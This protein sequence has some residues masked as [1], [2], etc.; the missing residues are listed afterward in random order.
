MNKGSLIPK[1]TLVEQGLWTDFQKGDDDS[2]GNIYTIY[3]D[4]LYN[5]GFKF[6][7]DA[8]LVEDCIQELFV[9]LLRNRRNLSLP[10][11]VRNY[12]F[13]ALRSHL[14]DKLEQVKRQSFIELNE[15]ID[16]HL[17]PDREVSIIEREKAAETESKL[18]KALQQLT[19]RQREAIFLK[20]Q[21]GFSYAE[22]A[23]ILKMTQKAV[24][25]LVG[26]AIQTLR[27]IAAP[28][29]MLLSI[30]S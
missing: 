27:T 11:S 9:K 10:V 3:F 30:Y 23:D 14:F 28:A 17:D 8:L 5:Y 13:G 21:E 15:K 26:R 7:R 16:F 25:K 18:R 1:H 19:P 2:L 22:I 12:L 20:Y 6:T 24:Y 4:S 29:V